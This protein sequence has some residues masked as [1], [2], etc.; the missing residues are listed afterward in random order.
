M[1]KY[2]TLSFKWQNLTIRDLQIWNLDQEI[3][4]NVEANRLETKS[5]SDSNNNNNHIECK[6]MCYI[7]LEKL[8]IW[9]YDQLYHCY[10]TSNTSLR[11]IQS[12][13]KWVGRGILLRQLNKRG[14]GHN[15]PSML[16]CL[17][18]AAAKDL[19]WEKDISNNQ[20]LNGDEK[21][22][23]CIT[24]RTNDHIRN[25]IEDQK[26]KHRKQLI[27]LDETITRL[28]LNGL[29]LRDVPNDHV[30]YTKIYKI[31][32]NATKFAIRNYKE[33]I[34]PILKLQETV[35]TLLTLFVPQ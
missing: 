23:V 15:Q 33:E 35:E 32:F 31:T 1:I 25:Y 14:N 20:A 18:I 16:Y 5:N 10:T 29:R 7:E 19:K 9:A 4:D 2:G 24:L 26:L 27:Q 13:L 21:F 34:P 17:T 28:I 12:K 3:N 6:Y 8:P 11:F 30:D 22:V